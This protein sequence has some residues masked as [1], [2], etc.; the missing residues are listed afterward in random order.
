MELNSMTKRQKKK[1]RLI[2]LTKEEES[3]LVTESRKRGID[4]TELIRR[5]LDQH[6]EAN[7]EYARSPQSV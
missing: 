7:Y 5:I 2:S 4:V 1:R 6:I 3:Y